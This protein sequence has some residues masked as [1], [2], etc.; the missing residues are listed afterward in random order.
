LTLGAQ[1]QL[2]L[3]ALGELAPLV[4]PAQ[5]GLADVVDGDRHPDDG[6]DA[7]DPPDVLDDQAQHEEHADDAGDT[8]AAGVSS[9]CHAQTV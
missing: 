7:D 2:L 5:G 3:M 8:A 6:G 4:R 1:P 9:R